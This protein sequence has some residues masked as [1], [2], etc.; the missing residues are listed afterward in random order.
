MLAN[1]QMSALPTLSE[2]KAVYN[3]SN[4]REVIAGVFIPDELTDE[5][6][7]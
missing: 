6:R 1:G 2:A 5:Y 4:H 3:A 7:M